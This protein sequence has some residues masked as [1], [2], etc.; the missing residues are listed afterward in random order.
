MLPDWI[1]YDAVSGGFTVNTEDK[2][3]VGEYQISVKGTIVS[4][5]SEF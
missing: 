4:E 3:L 2:S 1:T 5:V